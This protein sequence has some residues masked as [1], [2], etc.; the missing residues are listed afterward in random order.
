MGSGLNKAMTMAFASREAVSPSPRRQSP[1]RSIPL[2]RAIYQGFTLIELMVTLAVLAIALSVGVPTYQSLTAQSS[3]SSAGNDLLAALALA[4][5]EALKRDATVSLQA[6]S[7]EASDTLGG[8]YCVVVGNPGNC[9]GSLIRRFGALNDALNVVISGGVSSVSFDG[10]GG[11]TN[12]GGGARLMTICRDGLA[13]RQIDIAVA[14]RARLSD[15]S[16]C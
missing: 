10:L 15:F 3:I 11:L 2:S 14:G 6:V 16:G 7:A 8:G 4:R 12:A 1:R 9:S 5:S 13:G